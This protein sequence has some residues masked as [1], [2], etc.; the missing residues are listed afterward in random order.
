MK[1]FLSTGLCDA[2]FKAS[3]DRDMQDDIFDVM[4][5]STSGTVNLETADQEVL[6]EEWSILV[7]DE[8]DNN[9][10]CFNVRF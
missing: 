9:G 5:E 8:I 3:L 2:L 4:K 7:E 10:G 1:T 6:Q